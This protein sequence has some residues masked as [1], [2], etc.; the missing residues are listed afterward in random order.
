MCEALGSIQANKI[1][2][3]TPD[4]VFARAS[5]LLLATASSNKG[6]I[7]ISFLLGIEC[8]IIQD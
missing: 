3:K 6:T 8:H 1:N 7:A 4:I 5:H 2:N